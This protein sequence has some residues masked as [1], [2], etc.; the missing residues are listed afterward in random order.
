MDHQERR[1]DLFPFAAYGGHDFALQR[2]VLDGAIAYN[3][4]QQNQ[5][6]R[7]GDPRDRRMWMHT[8]PVV[9]I[10]AALDPASTISNRRQDG[11]VTLVDLKLKEGDTLTIA[12]RPPQNHPAWIRWSGPNVNLGEVA[13]TTHFY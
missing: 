12:I 10:R 4:N 8:N 11:G 6:V 5:A 7:A 1:N 9:A 13:Y 2:Q 3:V